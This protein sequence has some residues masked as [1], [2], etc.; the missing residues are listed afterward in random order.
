MRQTP[1]F[2][3]LVFLLA[4]LLWMTPVH[5]A[6]LVVTNTNATGPGSLSATLAAASAG[7]TITFDA[8]LS[9]G[10]I[11]LGSALTL[12]R[13]VT[14]DGSALASQ[15]RISGDS[16]NDGTGDVQV[17]RVN[18]GVTA[19]LESLTITK[20]SSGSG[21][22]G[23]IVSSGT[24]TISNST[25]SDNFGG[26][27]GGGIANSGTLTISNSTLS[28][29]SALVT[30]GGIYN[31]PGATVAITNSTLSGNAADGIAGGGVYNVGTLTISNSTFS[32]NAAAA[33]GGIANAAGTLHYTNVIV[34]N[35]PA[36]GDCFNAGTIATNTNNLVENGSC[37]AA[38]SGDPKLGPLASNGGPTQTFAL[39]TGSPAINAGTSTGAPITD[40]RGVARPQAGTIDI[41]AYE[42]DPAQ[43]GPGFVVTHAGAA[44]SG[45]CGTVHCTLREAVTAANTI[46]G[47]DTITFAAGLSGRTIFLGSTLVLFQDVTIDGSA[48]ASQIRISGDSDND[49][50]GDVRV[51][52]VNGGVTATLDGLTITKGFSLGDGGGGIYNDPGGTLTITN[53]TLS[54]NAAPTGNAGGG[55]LNSGTL[56][57]VNSTLVGNL[58]VP[59]GSGGGIFNIGTLTIT[60]STFSGNTGGGIANWNPGTLTI[61]NSTVS[62]NT[63]GGIVN[64][65]TLHYTNVIVAN[66]I[67][68]DDCFNIG[69]IA[70]NTN[71]LVETTYTCLFTL[72]G[73]PKLGPLASNGGPTQTFALLTGSP[74]I[75]AGTSTGAPATD[76]RGVARPQNGM[77]DIGAYEWAPVIT[78]TGGAPQST[79]IN[80]AFATQLQATV[81]ESGNPVIGATVTFTAP[82]SGAR[83]TFPGNQ[84]TVKAI[85]D[86]S[87]VA[88]APVLTANGIAGGPYGVVA[89]VG[90]APPSIGFALTNL[91]GGQTIAFG[92]LADR[93]IDAGSFTIG[94]TAT[95]TLPVT[96]IT[97][98]PAVC[99]LTGGTT[100]NTLALGTCTIVASQGGDGNYNAAAEVPRSFQV[101]PNCAIVA[102]QP[103]LLTTGLAGATYSQGLSIVNG[104]SPATFTLTGALPAGLTFTNGVISGTPSGK[105]VFP[106]TVTATDANACQVS[107][108]FLLPISSERRFIAGVGGGGS[109]V[110][111]ITPSAAL[112]AQFDAYGGFAGGVSV[113]QGDVNG[114]G[115]ADIITGAGPTGGPHVKVFDGGT[116]GTLASFFAFAPTFSSGVEVAAGDVTGDGIAEVIVTGGCAS[117]FVA[118]AFNGITGTLVREYSAG[119]P[120]WSC[121]LHV[122]AGDVNGDGLADIVLGSGGAGSPFVVVL[123]G[124]SG[125]PI[126]Q[127]LAYDAAFTGGVYVGAGDITGDGLADIVTG[128]GAG[129]GPHVSAFDGATGTPLAG[130]LGSFMAYT[131]AFTGGV[132][133][134]AGDLNGDGR[135]EVITAAGPGGGPHVR[136][137]N[138]ATGADMLGIFAFDPSMTGGV[139]VAAPPAMARMSLD[140]PAPGTT[141]GSVHIAGWA[142]K[143][144]GIDTAGTD[145]I[146]AWAYP[147]TGGVPTFVGAAVQRDARP[148]IGNLFGGEFLMSGFDFT[149]TLAPGTYDL[150]VFARNSRT[151]LFD[152]LRIV[153]VTVP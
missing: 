110:R 70:T 126:R 24:L 112:A 25:I 26:P 151:L 115:V 71:N 127:F 45:S 1:R 14:I 89:S 58:V 93:V 83:G 147:V 17:F 99:S 42:R 98:T 74:A 28:G 96:L 18:G 60:N 123:D 66:S 55:I 109:T 146:H 121:G 63:G 12:T 143:S 95:S 153:R 97:Q 43:T 64:L 27:S 122:A 111:A 134:A 30:G 32:G 19:T 51:F 138:G 54:G 34:A 59:H 36:G 8:A 62:G 101:L 49:G 105:G 104:A 2:A 108:S 73:D 79:P 92:A 22:G 29:N 136:V 67:G 16:N 141:N 103:G 76:Q 53:S 140:L 9:G 117:P 113:A 47:A 142:L 91:K 114:D 41:G 44:N 137:L 144:N 37:S 5:A 4:N 149:G 148:D 40:Q 119:T 57:I 11:F 118:R 145:A 139:F 120:V 84:T 135:A 150:V 72:R 21:L 82:G 65:G 90:A 6:T 81:T 31:L 56:T 35:S 61:T 15:I 68:G 77:V 86:A 10:T 131:P 85:T 46:S 106:I 23:G 13:N 87:G 132:R 7:D 116:G 20:G 39:L 152:Q 125:A 88:T 48:L 124:G 130:P 75:N 80:T 133:V 100:L 50:T 52:R 78:A 38:L 69:T 94:A 3:F 129:G 107:R 128:A 102:I 33:G